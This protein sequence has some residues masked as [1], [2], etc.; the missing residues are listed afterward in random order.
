MAAVPRARRYLLPRAIAAALADVFAVD[1][2]TIDAVMVIEHSRR[3]RWH[4]PHVVA[5]TRRGRIYVRHAGARLTRDLDLLLHEYFHVLLQWNTGELTTGRYL[6]ELLARGYARNRYE[7]AARA[8]ARHNVARL[9][10]LLGDRA[11]PP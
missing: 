4:G 5:T 9:G 3:V 10:A 2:R 11:P 8:F 1:V 6:R 7:M